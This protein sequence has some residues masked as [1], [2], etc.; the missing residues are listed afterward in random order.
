MSER[1]TEFAPPPVRFAMSLPGEGEIV[2][3][4]PS[5]ISDD[6]MKMIDLWLD[7]CWDRVTKNP[8]NSAS[9]EVPSLELPSLEPASDRGDA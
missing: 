3:T 7:R 9:D 6:S 4:L 1:W 8:G 2:L 5:H